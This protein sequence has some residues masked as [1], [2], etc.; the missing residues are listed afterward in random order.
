MRNY[1]STHIQYQI[2]KDYLNK[3]NI[4]S[5]MPTLVIIAEQSPEQNLF[6]H[7]ILASVQLVD[8]QNTCIEILKKDQVLN[9]NQ[10]K[11]KSTQEIILFGIE[12]N[13]FMLNGFE[14]KHHIYEFEGLKWLFCYEIQTYQIDETKKRQLWNALK[15]LKQLK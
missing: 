8:Q 11:L 14:L 12:P 4:V 15:T 1:K 7:K 10:L 5:T 13:Q 6:L 2:P 3:V 9:F